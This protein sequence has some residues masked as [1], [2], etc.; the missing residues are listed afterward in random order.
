MPTK[1]FDQVFLFREF[2]PDPNR[3]SIWLP[4]VEVT[5]VSPTYGPK[6]LPLYLD[7]GASVTTLKAELYPLI[8]LQRWDEGIPVQTSTGGGEVT[9]YQYT[10]TL[11]IFG[12]TIV[13]PIHLST[14]LVT[15]PPTSFTLQE[16]HE[17]W[18]YM[19]IMEDHWMPCFGSEMIY[20]LTP[21]ST[22][23]NSL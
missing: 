21:E 5:L 13:C 14:S 20:H 11:E 18:G 2:Q 8:G 12:K 6:N 7:T 19:R 17:K 22:I 1:D 23:L 15:L 9:V 16:I 10:A 4:L 3:P